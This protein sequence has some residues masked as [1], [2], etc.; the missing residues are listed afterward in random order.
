MEL[1]GRG[2]G[3][4]QRR[5]C[6]RTCCGRIRA[7]ESHSA[8]NLLAQVE[9]SCCDLRIHIGECDNIR[10]R[11]A[12]LH[13]QPGLLGSVLVEKM[14]CICVMRDVRIVDQLNTCHFAASNQCGFIT[15]VRKG[16][17]AHSAVAVVL[18]SSGRVDTRLP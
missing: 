15:L 11:V 10:S 14:R 4:A 18:T 1:F 8:H 17:R 16:E 3:R 2:A 5:F 6:R 13:K 7:A 12:W 9:I